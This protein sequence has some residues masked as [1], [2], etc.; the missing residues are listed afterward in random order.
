MTD[1][2]QLLDLPLLHCS[3]SDLKLSGELKRS[4]EDFIVEEVPVYL[5]SG[6]GDHLFLWVE[7]KDVSS[8]QLLQHISAQLGIHRNDIGMAGLKDRRA[9]TRQWISVPAGCKP[10]I[11]MLDTQQIRVLDAKLHAN[12]L[13]TGHLYGNRFTIVLRTEDPSALS[14][15]SQIRNELASKAYP[16]YFGA[17]RFGIDG[18]TLTTGYQLLTGELRQ[19]EIPRQ[20]RKFLTRLS[21]SAVQSAFFNAILSTRIRDKTC[22]RVQYGDVLQVVAS[23]GPFV[24]LDPAVDQARFDQYEVIT[25]GPIFGPKMK[26]PIGQ[27]LE[28]ELTFLKDFQLKLDHFSRFK[29]LTSGT[30]RPL[31]IRLDDIQIEEVKKGLRFQFELPKGI[32]ATTILREYLK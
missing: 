6:T 8:E 19:E 12:K 21:L 17:Q 1:V 9:V 11:G 31:L 13:K 32:Y 27:Q 14:I 28:F 22:D 25:S 5:P 29:K 7:K 18:E 4:P 26:M 3:A 20:R 30:R 10:K 16:N 2:R 15:A 23:G 24:S